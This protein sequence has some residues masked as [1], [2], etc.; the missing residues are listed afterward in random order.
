LQCRT[1][2]RPQKRSY[3]PGGAAYLA[4]AIKQLKSLNPD[5]AVVSA[6]DM[7]GASPLVSAMFLDEPTI[8]VFNDPNRLQRSGQS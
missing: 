8:E 3:Q 1:T 7:I 4:S 6:G 2:T 5:H